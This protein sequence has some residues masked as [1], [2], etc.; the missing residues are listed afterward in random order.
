N[1]Q[2][3]FDGLALG[4]LLG[5][6]A[7]YLF[8]RFKIMNKLKPRNEVDRLVEDIQHY[9]RTVSESDREETD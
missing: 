1:Y 3:F 8:F 9:Y 4:F 6:V 7:F 5:F 2:V